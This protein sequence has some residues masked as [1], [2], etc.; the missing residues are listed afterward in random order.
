MIDGCTL[1]W[2]S[3]P[4]LVVIVIPVVETPAVT[5]RFAADGI[6]PT[7]PPPGP[8]PESTPDCDPPP[9][10]TVGT[11]LDTE[12]LDAI[13]CECPG[14]TTPWA[15][16]GISAVVNACTSSPPVAPKD[17]PSTPD[18]PVTRPAATPPISSLPT[19]ARPRRSGRLK[20]VAPSPAPYI[21][22][23]PANSAA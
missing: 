15:C 22:P 1:L 9:K 11:K 7:V 12:R 18:A 17:S 23:I 14:S 5:E 16:D 13:S 4:P 3:P 8:F 21:V 20:V 6:G 10:P 19:I 2:A